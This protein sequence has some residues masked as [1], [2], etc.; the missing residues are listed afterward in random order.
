MKILQAGIT[1]AVLVAL[2]ACS[3]SNRNDDR[4]DY[5]AKAQQLPGLE[6][7]PD[8]TGPRSDDRFKI[9]QSGEGASTSSSP[10]DNIGNQGQ[11]AVLPALEWVRLE[12]DGSKR[13]LVVRDNA[14]NVWPVVKSFW[15]EIGLKLEIEETTAGVMETGWAENLAPRAKREESAKTVAGTR[16]KYITRLERSKDGTN[17]EVHISHRGIIEEVSANGT[18]WKARL[19]D[20]ELEAVML[21]RLML[22]LGASKAQADRALE[23]ASPAPAATPPLATD[24]SEPAGTA[25]L[26]QINDNVVVI[27]NDPFDRSWRKVGLA[28]EDSGLSVDDRDREKGVYYL[29]PIKVERGWFSSWRSDEDTDR[30]Y[31]V[32]VKDGG[33]ACEVTITDQDGAS[34]KASRQ[35]LEAL[36]K[37]LNKQ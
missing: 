4:F 24:T 14:D 15:L 1:F 9:P 19:S 13:W 36:Y 21:Q 37:N 33:I 6:V 12:R 20:T 3:T 31:R 10:F 17:T 8:L 35:M 25:S 22:R 18:G 26:R 5:G 29:R 27:V 34:N 2:S 7:P 28:I 23:T 32:N 30:Q 16:D 11:A